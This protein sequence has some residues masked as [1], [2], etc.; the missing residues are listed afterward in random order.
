[1]SNSRI[2]LLSIGG[3]LVDVLARVQDEFLISEGL[4]KDSMRLI[5]STE[6]ERLHSLIG[7]TVKIPGGC[8]ANTAACIA[9]LG[10]KARFIGKVADDSLGALFRREL[11][12]QS[13]LF[14]TASALCDVPTGSCTILVT[15]GGERTMNTLLGGSVYLT[16]EDVIEEHVGSA[17]ITFFEGYLFDIPAAKEILDK[18]IRIVCDKGTLL[19]VGLSAA[20]CVQRWHPE[21]MGLIR[22]KA[23]DIVFGNHEEVLALYQTDDLDLAISQLREEGV[24]AAVTLSKNGSMLLANGNVI[25]VPACHVD[26][27]VDTTGAGDGFAGG[28]LFGLSRGMTHMNSLLL[29]NI[30]ASRTICHIGPRPKI[31]L[32]ELARQHGFEV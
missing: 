10:G 7:P 1:V 17:A 13:V 15:P 5:D 20:S 2:D 28:F 23:V 32:V 31:S 29:G 19:A 9:S 26:K 22:S 11:V 12:E 25:S 4:L 3:A 14:D 21:I 16:K 18:I 24:L 6:A 27:V 30:I 8:C